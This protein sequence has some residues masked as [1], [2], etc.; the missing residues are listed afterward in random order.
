MI[1]IYHFII[2][3]KS[4][5]PMRFFNHDKKLQLHQKY[6]FTKRVTIWLFNE[7][8]NEYR[9]RATS[10]H[11]SIRVL[12]FSTILSKLRNGKKHTNVK[13]M[14]ISIKWKRKLKKNHKLN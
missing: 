4:F 12:E 11:T 9:K 2:N 13:R 7:V 14:L 8:L 6:R 10:K 1:T 5:L 3:P